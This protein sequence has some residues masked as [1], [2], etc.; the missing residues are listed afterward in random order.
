METASHYEF[1]FMVVIRYKNC[2]YMVCQAY[3]CTVVEE[4]NTDLSEP[5]LA[6]SPVYP[7]DAGFSLEDQL[8]IN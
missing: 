5:M 7:S 1:A 2:L 8:Y 3:R 4:I 6:V